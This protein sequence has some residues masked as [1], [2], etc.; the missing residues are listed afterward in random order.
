MP[1]V[2]FSEGIDVLSELLDGAQN[3][4]PMQQAR[5]GGQCD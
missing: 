3:F 4:G 1:I 2:S 5:P